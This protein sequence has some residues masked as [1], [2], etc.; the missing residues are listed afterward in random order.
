MAK[1]DWTQSAF[2]GGFSNDKFI[3]IRNSF[4]YAK[5][6][7]IRKNPN[8]LT[9]AYKPEAETISLTGKV[10]KMVTIQSTGDII[11]FCSDG[12]IFRNATGAGTWVLVYTDGGDGNLMNGIEYNNYL[13]WFTAGNLHRIAITDIDDDWTGDVTEDYKTFTNGNS[14]AHPAR[15]FGNNLYIGDGP[16]LAELDNFGVFTGEKLPIFGDEEI[17]S[18]TTDGTWIKLYS[19]RSS[20]IDFGAKYFWNGSSEAWQERKTIRQMFHCAIEADEGDYMIAGQKPYLYASKGL[21]FPKLKR[22]PLI[23]GSQKISLSP[24]ALD[25]TPDEI[26]AIA[27]AE[28]GAADIGRGI[29]T[30]GKEDNNYPNSLNFDYPTSNDNTTDIVDCVHLSNGELYFSWHKSDNTYGIDKVNRSKYATTGSVHSRVF[31]ADKSSKDK[32]ADSI[33]LGFNG[34]AAGEKIEAFLRKNLATSWEST[35]EITIDYN[36][37]EEDRDIYH[38]DLDEALDI[39]NFNFLETKLVLTAGTDQATTPEVTELSMVI[40]S[41]IELSDV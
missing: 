5:G 2:H 39:G 12:K 16:D 9:L 7:E 25:Y 8:S 27:V 40:D 23:T 37:N 18:I 14:N 26:L 19:R 10:R 20:K 35:A 11:A 34:V 6:V 30:Y 31:Y 29:F 36:N 4:R 3:G 38:K 21:S 33:K 24:N 41:E 17:R 1:L 15:E 22:L 32:E 13:Y 28:S